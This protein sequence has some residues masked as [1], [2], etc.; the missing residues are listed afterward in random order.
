[1]M[2]IERILCPVDFS[3]ASADALKSAYALARHHR[4]ALYV[5]HVFR[6]EPLDFECYAPSTYLAELW[7]MTSADARH[8]LQAFAEPY[9]SG[10]VEVS[11]ELSFGWVP[12]AILGFAN[13]RNVDLV[14]MDTH[15]KGSVADRVLRGARCPVVVRRVG[16]DGPAS[17]AVAD[18]EVA[19][20]RIVFCTDLDPAPRG[21]L[22]YALALAE[23]YDAEVTLLHVIERSGHVRGGDDVVAASR[24]LDELIASQAAGRGRVAALVRAGKAHEQI[25]RHASE[26]R[27]DLAVMPVRNRNALDIAVFGSTT[28]D[29]IRSGCCPVLAVHGS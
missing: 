12:G 7:E 25:I 22:E 24:R 6:F 8:R 21:V 10:D 20:R 5:Q 27:A 17:P 19:L 14:V 13:D 29:V 1:M 23:E 15:G 18:G 11:C 26:V 16:E 3:E 28:H 9:A 4:A 2:N